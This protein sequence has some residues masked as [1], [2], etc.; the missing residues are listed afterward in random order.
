[1]SSSNVPAHI[2]RLVTS[3]AAKLSTDLASTSN[4]TVPRLSIKSGKFRFVLGDDESAKFNSVK[5][6]IVGSDPQGGRMAKT[7]YGGAY[8]PSNTSPPDCSSSNGL[9]PDVWVNN[10]VAQSCAR[11]PKNAFGSGVNAQGQATKGKACKDSKWLWVVPLDELSKPQPQFYLL[12]VPIMSIKALS[13]YG[14]EVAKSGVPMHFLVT[15]IST[16]DTVDYMSLS[17]TQSGYLDEDQCQS[18][19]VMAVE[20]EWVELIGDTSVEPPQTL[21][22]THAPKTSSPQVMTDDSVDGVW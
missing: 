2:Q 7:Y 22:V 20:R 18:A 9:T 21:Q 19:E 1:M 10:P 8:D 5:V 6:A 16:D 17:F 15:E 3:S 11:C 12:S 4:A 14:R 13:G